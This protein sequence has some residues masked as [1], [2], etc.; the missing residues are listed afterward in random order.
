MCNRQHARDL[1]IAPNRI[2]RAP[3]SAYPPR[4]KLSIEIWSDVA[5]PWC[6]VGKREL[7]S[8]ISAF[9]HP[10]DIRWRAFEL[11]PGALREPEPMDYAERLAK[12]Y[13]TSRAGGQQMIDTMTERGAQSGLEFRFDRVQ[14]CNTFDAHRLIHHATLSGRGDAMKERLLRAYMNEGALVSDHDTL[15]TLAAEIGLNK[16]EVRKFLPSTEYTDGVRDEEA[17]AQKLGITGVPFFVLA[18]R[19]AVRGA[20]PSS[21]LLAAMNRAWDE[22][23][24]AEGPE[25]AVCGPEGC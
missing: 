1:A 19:Y 22:T 25:G 12:K 21:E 7:E 20:Q 15:T 17:A 5:C 10:V 13:G 6:W 18:G 24:D 8:A 4:V 3:P 9:E 2:D 14:P 16:D 23:A 11:N